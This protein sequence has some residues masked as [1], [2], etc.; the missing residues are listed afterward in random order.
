MLCGSAWKICGEVW[1]YG[2]TVPPREIEAID[3][4]LILIIDF[5][6]KLIL[7]TRDLNQIL[8]CLIEKTPREKIISKINKE[9]HVIREYGFLLT[10]SR[11]PRRKTFKNPWARS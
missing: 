2:P 1:G 11:K 8:C 3:Q 5:R 7:I 4:K 9:F 6:Q 10:L